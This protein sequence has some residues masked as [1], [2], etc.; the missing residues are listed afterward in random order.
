MIRSKFFHNPL[1]TI[2]LVAIFSASSSSLVAQGG[3]RKSLIR[4]YG[5]QAGIPQVQ[6]NVRLNE[7]NTLAFRHF[8]KNYASVEQ[9][10]WEKNQHGFMAKFTESDQLNLVYYDN[11]GSFQ[12][13]VR[14]LAENDLNHDLQKRLKR[15]FPGYQFDILS[16]INNEVR[17][18]YLVT[19]KNKYSMKSLMI[20]QGEIKVIEDLNYAGL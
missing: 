14:Y 8:R 5:Y 7:I 19:L 3:F 16:E 18:V 2:L 13:S 12:Y 1:F 15:E 9:A 11:E 17:T 10:Y 6:S 4:E 20:D